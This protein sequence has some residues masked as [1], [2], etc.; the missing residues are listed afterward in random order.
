LDVT[1]AAGSATLQQQRDAIA[2]QWTL[3]DEARLQRAMARARSGLGDY[4][5]HAAATTFVGD[6]SGAQTNALGFAGSVVFGLTGA[7]VYKDVLDIAH[8]FHHWEWSWG[9]VGNQ[10]LNMVATLPV[11]GAVKNLKYA[12]DLADAGATAAKNLDETSTVGKMAGDV[13]PRGSRPSVKTSLPDRVTGELP[14]G[15]VRTPAENAQAR[16]FFER[17]RDAARQWWE[18]RTGRQW[19]SDATHYEH[20]RPLADGGDPLLVEPGFGGPN[21]RHMIPGLDGVTDFQ[22]WGRR[23]GRPRSN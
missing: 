8:G 15:Q 3:E 21:A 4:L 14:A 23:G 7:D 12:D 16:N 6:Y 1:A 13:G 2:Q 9:H 22:R 18:Q 19:P 5:M 10:A 20:P 17:K 11:V